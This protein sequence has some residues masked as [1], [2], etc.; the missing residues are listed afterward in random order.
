MQYKYIYGPV[1]SWRLGRS[2]GVD[3]ISTPKKVCTFDCIYCQLGNYKSYS[4]K[5]KIFV[6][7]KGIIRELK[8]LGGLKTDYIT[9]SGMGEPL[10]AKNLGNAIVEIKKHFNIPIAVLTNSSLFNSP[11]VRKELRKADVVVAKLDAFDSNT[12]NKINRPYKGITFS[13]IKKGIKIFKKEFKGKF[14]LQ[15][16]FVS[17]NADNISKMIK[18]VKEINPDEIQINTPLRPSSAKPLSLNAINN[19]KKQF[20]SLNI[21]TVYDDFCQKSVKPVDVDSTAKRGRS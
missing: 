12:F 1:S 9:F 3:L 6:D 8:S 13:K 19:I 20:K 21:I 5:R 18:I 17:H 10:L 4:S 2:L 7:I 16:M 14:A 11:K 15:L